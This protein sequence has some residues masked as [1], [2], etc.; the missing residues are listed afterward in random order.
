MTFYSAVETNTLYAVT[1]PL[2][3]VHALVAKERH[4]QFNHDCLDYKKSDSRKLQQQAV[5]KCQVSERQRQNYE[6]LINE[7]RMRLE[8]LR[9]GR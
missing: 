2:G 9:E 3:T 8:S 5:D 4:C 6:N 7:Y 1:D